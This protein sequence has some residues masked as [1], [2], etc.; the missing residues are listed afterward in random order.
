M[1]TVIFDGVAYGMLLF[2]IA[3]GLS[4][5]MGLMHYVNLAHGTFAM[6]GGYAASLAMQHMALNFYASLVAGFVAAAAIGAICEGLIFRRLYRSSPLDQLLMSIGVVFVSIAGATYFCGP[7][8]QPFALPASLQGRMTILGV[9]AGHYRLFLIACGIVVFAALR[10][11]MTRTRYGAMVRA[12]VDNQRVAEGTGIRVQRLFMLTF[13]LG[14][15]LA[16]L[17]GAL[18]LGMLGLEPTFPLKYLVYF[19]IVVCVGGAGSIVGPFVAALMVGLID[20]AGKYYLP[21]IGAFF[22]YV[23][24]VAALLI[25]PNGILSRKALA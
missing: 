5:T 11:A 3:V 8:V 6:A 19:L 16:G 1:G 18:S 10:L 25:R 12:A 2:L 22:I 14:C 20:V 17:G 4:I 7:S 9:E 23:F 21:E 15:G 24:M 13:S